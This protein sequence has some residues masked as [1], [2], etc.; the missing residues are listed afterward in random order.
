MYECRVG[1]IRWTGTTLNALNDF[2]M[3]VKKREVR[4]YKGLFLM[5]NLHVRL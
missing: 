3:F 2:P 1:I 4:V 5:D